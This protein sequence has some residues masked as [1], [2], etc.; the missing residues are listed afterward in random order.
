MWHA[1]LF[2]DSFIVETTNFEILDFLLNA[3]LNFK[4]APEIINFQSFKKLC[5]SFLVTYTTKR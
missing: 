4:Q 3:Q 1:I 2:W 5:K